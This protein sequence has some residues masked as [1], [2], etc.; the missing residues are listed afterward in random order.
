MR[1]KVFHQISEDRGTGT[2]C[3]FYIAPS[4]REVRNYPMAFDRIKGVLQVIFH[5]QKTLRFSEEPTCDGGRI[6]PYYQN[7]DG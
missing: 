6:P 7:A 4:W 3:Q 1:L 5:T 2:R